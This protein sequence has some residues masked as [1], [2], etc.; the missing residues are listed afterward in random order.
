MEFNDNAK[1]FGPGYWILLHDMSIRANTMAEKKHLARIL[2][3]LTFTFPCLK[4]REHMKAYVKSHPLEPVVNSKLF[5]DDNGVDISF[6]VYLWRF[7]NA[8]NKRLGKA[9]VKFEDAFAFY[10][11]LENHECK[12]GECGE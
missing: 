1:Y 9:E 3:N 5:K 4:C 7:H 12:I 11:N 8:V 2:T 6:F 10:R